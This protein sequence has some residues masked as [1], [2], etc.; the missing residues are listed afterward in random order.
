MSEIFEHKQIKN[1]ISMEVKMAAAKPVF[2]TNTT[3]DSGYSHEL[4]VTSKIGKSQNF[5]NV[6]SMEQGV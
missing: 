2:R 1:T 6:C 4:T 5:C 3:R